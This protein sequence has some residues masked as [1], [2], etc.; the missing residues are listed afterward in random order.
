M[1]SP[2]FPTKIFKNKLLAQLKQSFLV[3]PL[4]EA[5]DPSQ[6]KQTHPVASL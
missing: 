4:Q 3:A 6:G 5:Q 2:A 1:H